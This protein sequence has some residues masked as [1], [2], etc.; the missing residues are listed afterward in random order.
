LIYAGRFGALLWWFGAAAISDAAD[1]WL[2]RR[3]GAE[4]RVGRVLDPLADKALLSGAFV[5]LAIRGAIPWWLAGLVLGR[6]VLIL[7]GAAAA[8]LVS[9]TKRNFPPSVWGKL[10]TIAQMT[11]VAA[12]ILKQAAWRVGPMVAVLGAAT[13]LLTVWSGVDYA[14]RLL[15][16]GGPPT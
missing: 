5:A 2:A 15:P 11:F 6:D 13:V 12:A 9:R 7:L 3:L 14:R 16:R 4:S 1:G 10:S 8:L